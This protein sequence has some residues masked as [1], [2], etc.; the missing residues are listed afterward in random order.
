MNKTDRRLGKFSDGQ[1]VC[2]VYI[3]FQIYFY[4][5]A[6]R[7]TNYFTRAIFSSHISSI[8]FVNESFRN[9]KKK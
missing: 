7:D 6:H 5:I 3:Y 8:P 1:Y 4:M 9:K 2:T